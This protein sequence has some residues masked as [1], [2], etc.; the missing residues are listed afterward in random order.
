MGQAARLVIVWLERV[1][2]TGN[3]FAHALTI[4]RIA[5]EGHIVLKPVRLKSLFAKDRKGAI[6]R[7]VRVVKEHSDGA[8]QCGNLRLQVNNSIG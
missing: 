8:A 3:R 1:K 2:Q 7:I 4:A 5:F 6:I